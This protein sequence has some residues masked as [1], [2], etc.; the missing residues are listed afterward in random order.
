MNQTR[1]YYN[2]NTTKRMNGATSGRFFGNSEWEDI[3]G[4]KKLEWTVDSP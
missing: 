4:Q 3:R 1:I 2:V